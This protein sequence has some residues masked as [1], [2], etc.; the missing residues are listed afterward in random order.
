M[1]YQISAMKLAS[2]YNQGGF[3]GRDNAMNQTHEH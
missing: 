3:I 2:W 1:E